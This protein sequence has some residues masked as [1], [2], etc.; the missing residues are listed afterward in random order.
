[1][2]T[3]VRALTYGGGGSSGG[4][5]RLRSEQS[6][7]R[8]HRCRLECTRWQSCCDERVSKSRRA[9]GNGEI[10]RLRRTRAPDANAAQAL[11]AGNGSA[12]LTILA[13]LAHGTASKLR[14]RYGGNT[15]SNGRVA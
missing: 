6:S 7:L 12:A 2:R 10:L 8:R 9:G 13:H 14:P 3:H 1:M 4:G 11:W 15:S 5:S